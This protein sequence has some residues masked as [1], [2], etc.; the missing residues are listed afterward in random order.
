MAPVRKCNGDQ[1]D[2]ARTKNPRPGDEP[3]S[4]TKRFVNKR[5]QK[6]EIGDPNDDELLRGGTRGR[7]EQPLNH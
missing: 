7:N 4:S 1:N 2:N 6:G 5:R 3:L